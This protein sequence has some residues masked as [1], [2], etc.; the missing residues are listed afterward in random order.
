MRASRLHAAHV[1]MQLG[2]RLTLVT[3][4]SCSMTGNGNF[5]LW[6]A[7][8]NL[9]D[10]DGVPMWP[11]TGPFVDALVAIACAAGGGRSSSLGK[12]P[13]QV[14]VADMLANH[15]LERCGRAAIRSAFPLVRSALEDPLLAVA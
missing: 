6:R 13:T 8:Q 10:G 4:S 9:A 5:D 14:D 1:K 15:T 11:P 12:S 2:L 3:P 7:V